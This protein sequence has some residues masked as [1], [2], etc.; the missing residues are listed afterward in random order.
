M[1]AL[2]KL[3]FREVRP[4]PAKAKDHDC[5]L[6]DGP[7]GCRRCIDLQGGIPDGECELCQAKHVPTKI[8]KAWD[9]AMEYEMCASCQV[10]NRPPYDDDDDDYPLDE[11]HAEDE[12]DDNLPQSPGT[13]AP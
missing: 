10:G 8:V 2:C 6:Y 5:E 1:F 12:Y 11:R 7:W 13:V 9:E 4:E 3:H